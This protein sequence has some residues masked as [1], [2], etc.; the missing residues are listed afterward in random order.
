MR[1]LLT[2]FLVLCMVSWASAAYIDLTLTMTAD[3]ETANIGETITVTTTVSGL[4]GTDGVISV[5]N[6]TTVLSGVAYTAADSG[7]TKGTTFTGD[8][9]T[10]VL[11]LAKLQLT[12]GGAS[13]GAQNGGT[14]YSFTATGD[15]VGTLSFGMDDFNAGA[16]QVIKLVTKAGDEAWNAPGFGL[17]SVTVIGDSVSIIPEPATIA[18]LG[19]GA[20]LLRR[21]K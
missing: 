8:P 5:E 20:L 17:G 6:L 3:K 1:K 18:I 4:T 16:Y 19:L 15:A 7:I 12:S 13:T 14:I 21:R 2:L 10:M 11:T 9:V